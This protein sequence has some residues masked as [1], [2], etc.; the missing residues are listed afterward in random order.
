MENKSITIKYS[1]VGLKNKVKE[2]SQKV[3]KKEQRAK[4]GLDVLLDYAK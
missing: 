1:G 4:K 3:E 2:A